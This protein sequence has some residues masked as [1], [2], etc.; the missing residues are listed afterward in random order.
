MTYRA[1]VIGVGRAGDT[2]A[3]RTGGFKVAYMH[4]QQYREHPDVKL[5]A[6]ADIN[7]ENLAAW[8]NAFDV[9]AGYVDHHEMLANVKPD[10]VSIC[11]Y[12]GL[13]ATMIKDC[14]RAGVRAILCEK[15]F[16][17]APAELEL[18]RRLIAETGVKV[19]VAH[20]RRY[21]PVFQRMRELVQSGTIGRPLLYSAGLPGWDLSEWGTHWFD[22]FRFFN[23]DA[24]VEWVMG[25]A[26]VRDAR[27]FGHAT[28]EQASAYMSFVGGCKALLDGGGD[29]VRPYDMILTG[30]EGEIR[31]LDNETLRILDATGARE[32]TFP[33]DGA[34]DDIWR[35][36]VHGL[37]DWLGGGAEP[38]TG[39]T[40]ALLTSELNLA[41]YLSAVE[42]DRI[43]LPLTDTTLTEW[44]LEL[45]ARSR[46]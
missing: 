46:A 8:Q 13:H 24:P 38:P 1:A 30:E 27:A 14:A 10:V 20:I 2:P 42:R 21:Q 33:A 28:E 39:A 44:P 25:Q 32:E 23:D 18:V 41:A 16:L 26:R 3:D 43:D 17:A 6:G 22:M 35:A 9:P 5:V 15:P 4:S 45:L 19:A 36:T 31:L 37:L 34:W 11:T 29:L 12:V 40:S 7:V